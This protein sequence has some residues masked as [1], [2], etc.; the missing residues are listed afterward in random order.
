MRLL[1]VNLCFLEVKTKKYKGVRP[2][3]ISVIKDLLYPDELVPK[4]RK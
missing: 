3:G 2:C 4:Y 1:F